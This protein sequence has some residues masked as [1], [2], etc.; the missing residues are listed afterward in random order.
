MT[1][2]GVAL[3]IRMRHSVA[4]W[5]P[6]DSGSQRIWYDIHHSRRGH[7]ADERRNTSKASRASPT[8]P[9]L[10]SS[11]GYAQYASPFSKTDPGSVHGKSKIPTRPS[12]TR[13]IRDPPAVPRVLPV[14]RRPSK[15]HTSPNRPRTTLPFPPSTLTVPKRAFT[16]EVSTS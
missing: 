8:T 1:L 15:S 9:H 3:E 2:T 5:A 12:N 13:P 4:C 10:A 14:T 7:E 16:H 6:C 11:S